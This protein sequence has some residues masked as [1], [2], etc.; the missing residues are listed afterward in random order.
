MCRPRARALKPPARGGALGRARAE[1]RVLPRGAARRGPAGGGGG[2]SG[3]SCGGAL[4]ARVRGARGSELLAEP[5]TAAAPAPPSP[6][7]GLR[8]AARAAAAAPAP[9]QAPF[10]ALRRH[11]SPPRSVGPRLAG[12]ARLQGTAAAGPRRLP[13]GVAA[14]PRPLRG[15]VAVPRRHRGA[16]GS[17]LRA[18]PATEA[19]AEGSPALTSPGTAAETIQATAAA[20]GA[21]LVYILTLW[22]KA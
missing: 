4:G 16:D 22:N 17:S 1:G 2:G 7:T 10:V 18:R 3:C 11:R 13:R 21:L 20:G 8:T 19:A 15:P 9:R 12:P 14:A 6:H 5:C